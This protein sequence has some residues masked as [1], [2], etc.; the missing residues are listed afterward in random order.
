MGLRGAPT[1]KGV[2]TQSDFLA[3]R[4]LG[5]DLIQGQMFAKPMAPRK[6]EALN[7]LPGAHDARAK[8]RRCR[9]AAC[10]LKSC[11]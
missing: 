7:R 9:L 4:E 10:A 11:A 1:L 8:L 5:F 3:V 2:E 6:F